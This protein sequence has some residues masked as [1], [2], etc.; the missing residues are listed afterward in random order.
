M[1]YREPTNDEIAEMAYAATTAAKSKA[2]ELGLPLIMSSLGIERAYQATVKAFEIIDAIGLD[3]ASKLGE[4]IMK[5][6]AI[7]TIEEAERAMRGDE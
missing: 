1:E 6:E 4:I 7:E 5:V 2:E 3:A